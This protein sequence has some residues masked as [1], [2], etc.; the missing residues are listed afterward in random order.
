M[1]AGTGPLQQHT[2]K[3]TTRTTQRALQYMFV[4]IYNIAGST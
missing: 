3:G 4:R 2:T 1:H